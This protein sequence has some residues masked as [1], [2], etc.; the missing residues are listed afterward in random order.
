MPAAITANIAPFFIRIVPSR[1]KTGLTRLT[2][3]FEQVS[4][5]VHPV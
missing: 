5:P 2:R 1:D 4:N 3:W